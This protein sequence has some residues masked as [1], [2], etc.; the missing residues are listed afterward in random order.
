MTALRDANEAGDWIEFQV[1]DTGIGMTT[2]QQAK[3][4]EAFTQ[5]DASTTRTYGGT[6]LGLAITK[7]FCRLMGG[8]V[9]LT[10][11]AGKGTTFVVRLPAVTHA[12]SDTVGLAA[13][14]RSEGPQVARARACADR[15]RGRR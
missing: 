6:G 14:K 3:V 13:E 10:S 12:A 1:R 7:S 2:D 11:E 5:A 4:F 15:S 8:D 9:T